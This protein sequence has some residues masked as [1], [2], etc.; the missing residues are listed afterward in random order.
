MIPLALINHLAAEPLTW[1]T[2]LIIGTVGA[3]WRT[4]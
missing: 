2:V 1:Y 3:Y 4:R